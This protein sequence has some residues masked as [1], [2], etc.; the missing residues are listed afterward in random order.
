MPTFTRD[1]ATIHYTDTQPPRRPARCADD[2]LRARVVVQR[3]DVSSADRRAAERVPLCRNRLAR[4][5]RQR[6]DQGRL[7]HGHAGRRRRRPH[8]ASRRRARALCRAV[9]GRLHRSAH[10]RPAS[11]ADPH[12]HASSTPAQA[13]KT[14]TRSSDTSCSAAS[15][16]S[17]ASRRCENRCCPSCSDPRSSSDPA[18]QPIIDEWERRLKRCRRSGVSKAVMGV[19]NRLPI[20]ARLTASRRRPSSSSAPTTW[21]PRRTSRNASRSGFPVRASSRSPPAGTPARS[22]SPTTVTAL[23]RN[24]LS[25]N[26]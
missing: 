5:G 11:G 12:A 21:R 26:G 20:E 4:A 24:F 6:R 18:G 9:D 13:P 2:V 19:A 17:P 25:Q 7:R 22:S 23:L 3:L 14:P 10:R 16:E 1:G 8:R 15:T